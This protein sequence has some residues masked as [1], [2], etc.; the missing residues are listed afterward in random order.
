M[1]KTFDPCIAVAF[2]QDDVVLAV[3][4]GLILC[5]VYIWIQHV[6][7]SFCGSP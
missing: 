5:K 3:C 6:R 2:L 1:T 7:V 4:N